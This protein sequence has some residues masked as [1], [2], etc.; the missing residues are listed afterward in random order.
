MNK[1][2]YKNSRLIKQ[3]LLNKEHHLKSNNLLLLYIQSKVNKKK[4]SITQLLTIIRQQ[5]CFPNLKTKK[6]KFLKILVL[7]RRSLKKNHRRNQESTKIWCNLLIKTLI[8]TFLVWTRGQWNKSMI[9]SMISLA[10]S[11]KNLRN[12]NK[13]RKIQLNSLL[14]IQMHQNRSFILKI[15]PISTKSSL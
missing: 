13:Q 4:K 10:L 11:N 7:M 2:D 8:K 12:R 1:K 15:N 6:I 9:N 5:L 3:F 14:S